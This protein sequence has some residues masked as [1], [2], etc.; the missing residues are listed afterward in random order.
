[1]IDPKTVVEGIGVVAKLQGLFR[2]HTEDGKVESQPQ[3]SAQKLSDVQVLGLG[4][5]TEQ[6]AMLSMTVVACM[7]IIAIAV[8]AC[9]RGALQA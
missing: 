5:T 7:A 4:L 6:L 9:Q 8:V 2:R 1:M 3:E